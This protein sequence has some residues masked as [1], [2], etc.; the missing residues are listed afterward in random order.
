MYNYVALYK[1]SASIGASRGDEISTWRPQLGHQA[2]SIS[3]WPH[4]T[5]MLVAGC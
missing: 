4:V 5:D 2:R 3:T 1:S